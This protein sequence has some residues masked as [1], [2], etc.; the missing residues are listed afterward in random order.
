[1]SRRLRAVALLLL[2]S[3]CGSGN[4]SAPRELENACAIV[5]QRPTYLRA[6][7]ATERKWGIPVNVQMATFYQESKFIGNARTPY[8]FVLGVI[9]MG[10]QSSAYGY[11]Q[12]LDATWDEYRREQ[13]RWGAKRDRI[14][15]ATDFMGWYMDKSTSVL[16]ISKQDA[17][18]QYLA[19]HEGRTGY[20]RGSYRAKSWLMRVSTE[21]G[22]RSTTYRQQLMSCRKL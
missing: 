13:N 19:Y 14:Q 10:R 15:D 7:K 11:A 2:V 6:M 1:M 8:R 9:P 4:F 3:A 22:A 16:G 12:A 18:S 20:A 17:T 21:V 5:S